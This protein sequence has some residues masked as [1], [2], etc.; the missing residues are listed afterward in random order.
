M[1]A[2]KI[3]AVSDETVDDSLP[4]CLR[5]ARLIGRDLSGQDFSG[6]D[7]S[8]ADLSRCDLSGC[9]FIGSKLQGAILHGANLDRAEFLGADLTKAELSEASAIQAGFGHANLSGA[10]LVQVQ[11]ANA[12]LSKANLSGADLRAAN[13][14][15]ANLVEA[16]QSGAN[17]RNARLTEA[18][19][20]EAQL[21]EAQLDGANLQRARLAH[22]SGY[23]TASWI[24][25]DIRDMDCAGALLLRRHIM[26]E[27]YLFEFRNQSKSNEW[28]Y[29]A[30][31]LSSDCG[32]SFGRWGLC[33]AVIGVLFAVLFTQLAIDYGDHQTWL[34]PLYYSVVTLTTLG[35]GDV[36]PMS[37]AAQAA[38]ML[39]V[40][41]GYVML[42]GALSI[43]TTKMARRAS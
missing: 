8:G 17:L 19:M 25:A 30:W 13:L 31:S 26:D 5:E 20:T 43:F 4:E 32:R 7:L 41:I 21:T 2:P 1:V 11:L 38:S 16:N 12:S 27:N 36:L 35:Y 14:H 18:D 10:V 33:T 15:G 23:T 9:R 28:I 24:G 37:V 22:M 34:S 3:H 39:E 40:I 29:R 42:G 6:S